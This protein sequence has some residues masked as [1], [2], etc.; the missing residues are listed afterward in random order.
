MLEYVALDDGTWGVRKGANCNAVKNLV[1]PDTYEGKP[2]TV[3]LENAFTG[4]LNLT[5]VSF[6]NTVT[7]VGTGAFTVVR[8]LKSI[9][10]R[11][12]PG[13]HEP[14][15]SSYDG[16]LINNDLGVSYLEFFPERRAARSPFP[17]VFSPSVTMH[18]VT[19]TI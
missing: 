14:I 8:T 13:N 16:A 10:V 3:I 6:P 15:Y 7:I 4:A 17:R 11:E 5:Y 9:E 18:F 19:A 12:V 1:I 2:I